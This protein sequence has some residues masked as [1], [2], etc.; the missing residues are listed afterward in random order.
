MTPV[1]SDLSLVLAGACTL[2]LIATLTGEVLRLRAAD[3]NA[4]HNVEIYMTRVR[5]W[6]GMTVLTSLALIL[7]K[8][9][10][11]L[12]FAFISFAALREF[13]TLTAKD[14]GDHWALVA[15]FYLILPGQYALIWYEL[16]GMF[17]IFIPVYAFL[18]LPIL[19]AL[20]GTASGYLKRVSQTQWA[21]MICVYCASHV[22]ALL[23]LEIDGFEG[24]SVLLIA[25]LV[26]VVQLGDLTDYFFGRRFG[27]RLIAP[28]ISPRRWE[29]ATMGCAVAMG[30]GALLGLLLPFGPVGAALMAAGAFWMGVGGSLVLKAIKKNLGVKD[31]GHLIPG[32]GGFLDQM[33]SVLFAAP[34]FF[35]LTRYFWGN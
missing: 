16:Y 26:L 6:W 14:K 31:M 24:R 8:G 32:Q 11:I 7:G 9:A 20:R 4:R 22:P 5:S 27:K 10:L 13:L 33:D 29:G 15:A 17:S 1:I 23:I 3:S 12:L 25:F 18:V 19:S 34:V 35:H 30:T 21:L 28:E 2:L